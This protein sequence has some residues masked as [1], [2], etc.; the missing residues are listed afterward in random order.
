MPELIFTRINLDSSLCAAFTSLM[1]RY[2]PEISAH[3]ERP[4]SDEMLRSWTQSIIRLSASPDRLI[5]VCCD[6]DVPVGFLYGKI[7]RE[8]D[9]GYIRPGWGYVMEFYVI[10][11]RRRE[12][13][14]RIMAQ[15]MED[16]F[17]EKG[18]KQA[19]LTADP[20][21][22]KPFWAAAGYRAMGEISPENGQEF[23]EKNLE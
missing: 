10:P 11:E 4:L 6:G 7:D 9:R 5:E 16:F 15:R 21:T 17:R 22:G 3:T 14:G 13:L 8:G 20:V 12:G 1:H 23:F 2:G 19:Y 18:V